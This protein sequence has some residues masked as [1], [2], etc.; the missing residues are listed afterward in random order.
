MTLGS[1]S[2]GAGV[3]LGIPDGALRGAGGRH[4]AGA[5]RGDGIPV[6]IILGIRV[7]IPEYIL[8]C[9]RVMAGL[10]TQ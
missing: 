2:H 9:V 4:G 6:I 7:T 8:R 1:T 10:R 5:L 3:I